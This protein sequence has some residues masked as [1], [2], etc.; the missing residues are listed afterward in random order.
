MAR[1]GGRVSDIRLSTPLSVS[2]RAAIRALGFVTDER[3][4]D[5]TRSVL[6]NDRVRLTRRWLRVT[7]KDGTPVTKADLAA[8]RA[9]L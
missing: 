3:G 1:E 7:R 4:G 5:P 2:A 6:R 9:C 8:V